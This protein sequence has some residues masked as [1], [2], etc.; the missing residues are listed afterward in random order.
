MP[1]W[2]LSMTE[3]KVGSWLVEEGAEVGA[4]VELVEIETDKILSALEAPAPGVL[5]R[6]V[7]KEGDMVQVAGLLGVFAAASVPDSEIAAFIAD[8]R[9]RF[10][11]EEPESET[12]SSAPAMTQVGGRAIRYL[13][14]GNGA[15]AAVLIHG[16]GGDL[17]T[18]MFNHEDLAATRTVYSLDLPG[19]GASSKQVG[20][21]ALADFAKDLG[22]FMDAVGVLKAHLAGHSMGGA[23]ALEFALAHPERTRSLVLIASAGLGP[24]IDGEYI[25]G[26]IT[27]SRRKELQRHV[28]KLFVNPKLISRQLIEDIL[29]YKRLDGV[30][31]AL[32]T[33]AAQFCPGGRQ[34]AELRNQLDRLSIPVLVIW[35]AEDRILPPSHA[36]GLPESIRVEILAGSGH[37]VQMEAAIKVNRLIRS[38]WERAGEER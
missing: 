18:W 9:A 4:G 19:H 8:F 27:A 14:R 12:A 11:A 24:E 25:E 16:F 29:K 7:V 17:N 33:I 38:F 32:R 1:K 21:G 26:F 13:K 28:E 22:G 15:E 20:G 34:A 37:M 23:L 3:G 5:R 36:R 35:G 31:S 10:V 2:G 6:K 30:E